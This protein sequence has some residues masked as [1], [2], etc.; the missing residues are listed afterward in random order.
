[1]SNGEVWLKRYI[2]STFRPTLDGI[3]YELA[4]RVK[5]RIQVIARQGGCMSTQR[6]LAKMRK[7]FDLLFGK[8]M[9]DLLSM[10]ADDIT[11][12]IVPTN[13]TIKG[14]AQ[15]R[16]M[17]ENHWSAS[18]D[19][20]KKLLNVFASDEYACLEYITGGTLKGEAD[21]VTAKVKPTGRTFELQCCFVF[22]FNAQGLIDNVR[23]YFDMATVQRSAPVTQ[24]E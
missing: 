11:W 23:E 7:Y 13:T 24:E 5:L 19:R 18:P 2:N 3:V 22:H 9:D 21:F 15:F 12:F 8:E 4:K 20:I 6:N 1:M 16:T 14:K 17:A 10:F